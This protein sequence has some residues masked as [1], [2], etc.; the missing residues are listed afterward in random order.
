MVHLRFSSYNE[1]PLSTEQ[2]ND[3]EQRRI[4]YESLCEYD[5]QV[6]NL[7][8]DFFKNTIDK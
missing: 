3:L 7:I 4:E 8:D 1:K 6:K 2:V 5:E